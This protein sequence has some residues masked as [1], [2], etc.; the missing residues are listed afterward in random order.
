MGST[1][2]PP[3]ERG[4]G[5][6]AGLGVGSR[7]STERAVVGEGWWGG[8]MG[9]SC[10]MIKKCRGERS[11]R[12]MQ[13]E[14]KPRGEIAGVGWRG[15]EGSGEEGYAG[16]GDVFALR[17]L[18]SACLRQPRQEDHVARVEC[19]CSVLMKGRP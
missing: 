9:L 3:V 11:E 19:L 15:R 17:D 6:G 2:Y 13:I 10:W 8:V 7:R 5:R 16:G 14:K 1:V 12:E 4:D 18:P